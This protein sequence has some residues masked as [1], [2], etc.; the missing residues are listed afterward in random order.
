MGSGFINRAARVAALT[1]E[2]VLRALTE[3]LLARDK[4]DLTECLIDG[5]F[6]PAKKG[7]LALAKRSE[8]R[9]LTH[10]HCRLPWPS[11][12]SLGWKC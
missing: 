1:L 7:G 2:K 10:G 12:R 4:L 5:S 3:D 6:A 9:A 11:Y 8:E